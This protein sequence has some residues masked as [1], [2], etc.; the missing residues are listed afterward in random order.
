MT[1]EIGPTPRCRTCGGARSM[2]QHYAQGLQEHNVCRELERLGLP[3]PSLGDDCAACNGHGRIPRSPVGPM[4]PS[5]RAL[6]AWAPICGRCHGDGTEPG[7]HETRAARLAA[8]GG[9]EH[10]GC[11]Y[12]AAGSAS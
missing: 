9:P 8:E 2:R 1:N 3:T 10:L 11:G 4:N 5:Q 7:T 12:C 6:D